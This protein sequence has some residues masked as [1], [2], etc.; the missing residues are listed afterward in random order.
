L[1]LL[2]HKLKYDYNVL[3]KEN[4]ILV[5][6]PFSSDVKRSSCVVAYAGENRMFVKGASEIV[7]ELCDDYLDEKM[8]SHSLTSEFKASLNKTIESMAS[9]G[10]RTLT[11]AY[12]V[13][14]NLL[15]LIKLYLECLNCT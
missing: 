8:K 15:P 9:E 4:K 12:K 1:L 10:L 3:R 5:S 11:I 13:T 6:F 14:H 2:S 7:L